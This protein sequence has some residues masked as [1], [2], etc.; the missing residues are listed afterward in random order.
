MDSNTTERFGSNGK[1]V[2]EKKKGGAALWIIILLA[3]GCVGL[4]GDKILQLFGLI[5]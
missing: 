5:N 1:P 3:I 2:K 4:A